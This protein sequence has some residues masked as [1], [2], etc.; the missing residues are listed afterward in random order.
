MIKKG[1]KI[2]LI[3]GVHCVGKS[4]MGEKLSKKMDTNF[5][6]T[7]TIKSISR[8]FSDKNKYYGLHFFVNQEAEKYLP[9]TD[10]GRI[11]E[12]NIREAEDIWI[13][14]KRVIDS[15]KYN[16]IGIIEGIANLP[17]LCKKSRMKDILPVFLYFDENNI[18]K[19]NLFNRGLWGK[20]K[21]L[22]EYELKYLIEFN[23]YIIGTAQKYNYD[24]VNV[25]PYKTL[26]KRFME[27]IKGE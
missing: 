1:N 10:A 2:I 14:I 8:A 18:I 6:S 26:Q 21:K 24:C 12:D 27:V 9:N 23:K 25:Y 20:S 13:G 19:N 16:K 7:D 11:I 5:I 17:V 3:G 4:S 22:K 15:Y